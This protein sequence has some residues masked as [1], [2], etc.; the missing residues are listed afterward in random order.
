MHLL[1][2]LDGRLSTDCDSVDENE[3]FAIGQ[4]SWPFKGNEDSD[5]ADFS[6]VLPPPDN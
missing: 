6:Q 4:D 5:D 2:Q 1:H 3:G